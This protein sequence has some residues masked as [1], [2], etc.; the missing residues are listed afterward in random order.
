MALTLA[1]SHASIPPLPRGRVSESLD[2]KFTAAVAIVV[3]PFADSELLCLTERVEVVSSNSQLDLLHSLGTVVPP[4]G[5][6]LFDCLLHSEMNDL[7]A[8]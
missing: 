2:S 4:Q 1:I 7:L 8:D 3:I 6:S 5:R